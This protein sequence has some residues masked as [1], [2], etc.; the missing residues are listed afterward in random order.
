MIIRSKTSGKEEIMGNGGISLL[1]DRCES[2]F[3]RHRK[4]WLAAGIMAEE[5]RGQEADGAG[6]RR[7]FEDLENLGVDE[8]K[9]I[10]S[11]LK[12]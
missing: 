12:S 3:N 9:K 8:L 4:K 5:L 10:Y 6:L 11:G 2:F 1:L 7:G